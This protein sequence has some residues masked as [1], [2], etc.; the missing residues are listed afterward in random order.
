M[1]CMLIGIPSFSYIYAGIFMVIPIIA[2]LD[3]EERRKWKD[4]LYLV[5]MLLVILPL[6][7]CWTEGAGDPYYS[8]TH[9]SIPVLIEGLSLLIMTIGLIAEGICAVLLEKRHRI[10]AGVGIAMIFILAVAMNYSKLS[11]AYDYTNY[12][13]QTL[14]DKIALK[15]NEVL[16]QEFTAHGNKLDRIVLKAA[17]GNQG[18][19]VCKL[20]LK[21]TGEE[22]K[23]AELLNTDIEVGY[24]IVEFDDC[25]LEKGEE[26]VLE[27]SVLDAGSEVMVICRTV[28]NADL[29]TDYARYNGEITDW[30][31]GVQIYEYCTVE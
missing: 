23:R 20:K 19:L 2:F 31:L 30:H 15:E 21:N 28:D 7:F 17:A 6:P 1:T 25:A 16:E 8:Y 9:V 14:S 11:D 4:I 27:L 29:G 10:K 3:S 18:T 13:P 24:N 5:G 22:I 12:L 26:Y